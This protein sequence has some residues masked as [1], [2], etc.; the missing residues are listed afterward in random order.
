M[1]AAHR[2]IAT[3]LAALANHGEKTEDLACSL[4]K[5]VKE[6]E[7]RTLP[8]FDEAIKAA[9]DENGWNTRQGRPSTERRIKVPHTV[10]TYVWEMRSALRD[11]LEIW[12]FKTFYE[13]RLARGNMKQEKTP[14][15][16][17]NGGT[18]SAALPDVPEL[19]GVRISGGDAPNGALFHDMILLFATI[20]EGQRLMLARQLNQL[21]HKYQLAAPAPKP[22]K[23]AAATG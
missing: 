10:R 16:N 2:K 15:A 23:R 19:E 6:H 3:A 13:L 1:K 5:V 4:L 14:A 17:G 9:Y 21:L 12:T 20:E 18:A 8:E 22:P 7:I 11:G